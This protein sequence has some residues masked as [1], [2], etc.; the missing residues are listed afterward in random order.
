[1]GFL[2]L[3]Y[4]MRIQIHGDGDGGV[5]HGFGHYLGVDAS[6]QAQ[7][8]IRMTQP[9]K[10]HVGQTVR[11]DEPGERLGDLLGYEW[12]TVRSDKDVRV[13]I[14]RETMLHLAAPDAVQELDGFRCQRDCPT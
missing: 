9:V 8:R 1:M 7:G 14:S 10:G 12:Q 6:Q 2:H 5:T 13:I 4:H 3:T 11:S